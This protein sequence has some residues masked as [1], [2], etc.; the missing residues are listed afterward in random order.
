MVMEDTSDQQQYMK[1]LENLNRCD[2]NEHN[3]V[4][5]ELHRK[6]IAELKEMQADHDEKREDI[7]KELWSQLEE[8]DDRHWRMVARMRAEWSW[9]TQV[10]NNNTWRT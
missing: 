5:G 1:D 2:Q 4:F 8:R 3:G 7:M 9:R 6:P 10:T